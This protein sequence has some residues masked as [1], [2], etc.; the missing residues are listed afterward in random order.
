VL[1]VTHHIDEAVL[2]ADRVLVF[3]PAPGR[4]LELVRVPTS[5]PRGPDFRRDPA[6]VETAAHIRRLFRPSRV[7][8]PGGR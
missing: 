3:S 1:F 7:G 5:R 6:F 8:T 4:I 2:L